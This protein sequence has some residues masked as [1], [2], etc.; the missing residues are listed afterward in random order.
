MRHCRSIALLAAVCLLGMA[1][2][3]A[4]VIFPGA[5]YG[6]FGYDGGGWGYGF[7]YQPSNQYSEIAS[8]SRLLGQQAAMQQN[9]VVQSGIRNT[10]NT[11]AQAQDNAIQNQRQSY[12]DWWFQHQSGQMAER[13]ARGYNSPGPSGGSF[14]FEPPPPPKANLDIIKWPPLLQE[15]TFAPQRT[16]IEAPYRR[17]PP[18]LSAPTPQDYSNMVKTI[19]QMKGTLQWLTTQGVDAQEY[20][21]AE[22]FLNQMQQEAHARS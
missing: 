9:M 1:D 5:R 20:N 17:S 12:R 3:A 18:G 13:Q 10:L 2:V 7:G 21:Q 4:A 16:A 22:A 8:Q 14:G 11:Q 6:G 15:P 19:E